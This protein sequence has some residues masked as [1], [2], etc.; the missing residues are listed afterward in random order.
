MPPYQAT[1]RAAAAADLDSLVALLAVL[2][3]L[4][5]DFTADSA[6]QRR[7]LE[8]M[9]AHSAG[10]VWV[11]EVEGRVIGMATG[12]ITLSTAEGGAALLVEDVVVQQEWRGQGTGRR[13]MN[14]LVNWAGQRGIRRLQ[15]LADAN[16]LPALAFYQRL[17]WESTALICLRQEVR[18]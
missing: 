1:I 10:C 15:L 14:A 16:N 3:A 13:L 18:N 2:F 6:R 8:L 11:A 17:G 12:Q 9:L 4:E 5:A 7:G